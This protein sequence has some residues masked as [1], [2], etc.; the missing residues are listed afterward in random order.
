MASP[1][2]GGAIWAVYGFTRTAGASGIWIL[3][4]I[5]PNVGTVTLLRQQ[6]HASTVTSGIL[7]IVG[8]LTFFFMG[9]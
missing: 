9:L 7:A 1:V 6:K 3:A 4:T 5:Q 8:L 2:A